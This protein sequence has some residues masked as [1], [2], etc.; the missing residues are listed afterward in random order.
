MMA[1]QSAMLASSAMLTIVTLAGLKSVWPIYLLTAIASAATAFDIPA[2]QALT[3]AL[4]PAPI[5]R[6]L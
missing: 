4:V 6:T 1:T 5:L 3:P 2:R